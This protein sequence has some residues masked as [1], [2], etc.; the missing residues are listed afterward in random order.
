MCENFSVQCRLRLLLSLLLILLVTSH[1]LAQQKKTIRVAAAADLMPLL[2]GIAQ[3]YEKATGTHVEISFASSATLAT[4]IL[5]GAPMDL[6]LA[7]DYDFPQKIVAARLA[8]T[9]RPIPYARG[10]LVLWARKDSPVQPISLAT[11][12]NP[13]LQRLAVANPNHAPYGRAAIAALTSMKLI[14]AL[15]PRF[16]VAENIAQTAQFAESGNAQAG[17]LSLTAA[18][19]EHFRK[20]GTYVLIPSQSYPPLRQYAVV[21][22]HTANRKAAHAFLSFLLSGKVQQQLAKQGLLP[23]Q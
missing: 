20:L 18:S 4:Q 16:V 23:A 7:A 13:R 6:F 9:P 3:Q 17:L 21:L 22:L 8:D 19:T 14:D 12:K 15:R 2:P 10:A 1:A 11:L 5:N